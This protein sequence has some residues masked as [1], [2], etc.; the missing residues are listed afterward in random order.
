MVYAPL[1]PDKRTMEITTV[2]SSIPS[3]IGAGG[4]YSCIVCVDD[5]LCFDRTTIMDVCSKYHLIL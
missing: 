4:I 5:K 3:Q 1:S 2:M